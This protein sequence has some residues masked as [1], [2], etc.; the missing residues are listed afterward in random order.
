MLFFRDWAMRNG[1]VPATNTTNA[2]IVASVVEYLKA[3]VE[4][5]LFWS[6]TPA[7][8]LQ[9]AVQAGLAA[10]LNARPAALPA[11]AG[12]P[13]IA[14]YRVQATHWGAQLLA[15]ITAYVQN[16][17]AQH[18]NLLTQEVTRLNAAHRL[19]NP[20]SAIPS[21]ADYFHGVSHDDGLE[22]KL[23]VGYIDFI[24]AAINDY[25][26]SAVPHS[27]E[28]HRRAGQVTTQLG[29]CKG[30]AHIGADSTV[31]D[32]SIFNKAV[33]GAV[34]GEGIKDVAQYWSIE[35]QATARRIQEVQAWAQI[36]GRSEDK[37]TLRRYGSAGELSDI[38]A[39]SGF[40]QKRGFSFERYK[41]FVDL[42][43]PGGTT[44]VSDSDKSFWVHL[45]PGA[46]DALNA[47]KRVYVPDNQPAVTFKPD[48]G[49]EVGCFD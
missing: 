34:R 20:T 19:P 14:N 45:K 8:N 22:K 6:R 26:T 3:I 49:G 30:D 16:I 4:E 5:A 48:I 12:A 39:Q 9:N 46:L 18:A 24:I 7:N 47:V 38:R 23:V 42:T 13:A 11:G 41:W 21:P 40:Y 33:P 10:T 29:R 37:E 32:F 44:S 28:M 43:V 2:A 25:I 1:K 15:A 35:R 36:Q 17:Q 31:C 27:N